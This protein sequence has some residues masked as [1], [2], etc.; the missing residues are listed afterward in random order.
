MGWMA[1][2]KYARRE[3]MKTPQDKREERTTPRIPDLGNRT[4][5]DRGLALVEPN[6][7]AMAPGG[8]RRPVGRN[9]GGIVKSFDGKTTECPGS[10]IFSWRRLQLAKSWVS[11][12]GSPP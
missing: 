10:H 8:S 1:L 7:E 4:R 2:G 9:C 6:R 11:D 12:K 3:V 5:R